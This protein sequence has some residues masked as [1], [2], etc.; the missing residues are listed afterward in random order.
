[1]YL[2]TVFNVNACCLFVNEHLL[3][4]GEFKPTNIN[5]Q[6][7]PKSSIQISRKERQ[8]IIYILNLFTC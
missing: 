7:L 3:H 6:C 2:L 5:I 4:E 8:L 1:M